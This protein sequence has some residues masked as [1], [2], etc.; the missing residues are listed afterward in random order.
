MESHAAYEPWERQEGRF[1][2]G[3]R[4]TGKSWELVRQNPRLALL[5]GVAAIAVTV[6]GVVL[7]DPAL[8]ALR[9]QGGKLPIAIALGALMLPMTL[10]S[11]Y[12]NVAFLAA[13]NDQLE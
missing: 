7:F 1:E 9:H 6:A 11:T 10:I 5:P 3:L 4:L 2:R 12:F 13:V 8:Y